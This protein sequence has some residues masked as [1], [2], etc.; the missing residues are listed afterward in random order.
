MTLA[1]SFAL[2]FLSATLTNSA[3]ALPLAPNATNTVPLFGVKAGPI[4]THYPPETSAPD[5]FALIALDAL[6]KMRTASGL[7]PLCISAKLQQASQKHSNRMSQ[8]QI[9]QHSKAGFW[10]NIAVQG[11]GSVYQDKPCFGNGVRAA[12][13]LRAS[14]EFT[15]NCQWFNSPAHFNGMM[16]PEH[17]RAG[18][19]YAIGPYN[20]FKGFW[21][22]QSF[23]SGNEPCIAGGNSGSNST[24]PP[25]PPNPPVKPTT[26]YVPN[27]STST[28]LAAIPIRTVSSTSLAFAT[29]STSSVIVPTSSANLAP[30]PSSTAQVPTPVPTPD[31]SFKKSRSD[32]TANLVPTSTVSGGQETPTGVP[33]TTRSAAAEKSPPLVPTQV[34]GDGSGREKKINQEG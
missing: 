32:T 5:E 15:T 20:G 4:P 33:T 27:R 23:D 30:S 10:E 14:A 19:A 21:W 11:E 25:R 9:F 34:A 31:C 3:S 18:I 22:T 16:R 1:V 8:T 2:F 17:T 12:T 24:T 13:D 29:L 28:T 7:G 26:S 6:N